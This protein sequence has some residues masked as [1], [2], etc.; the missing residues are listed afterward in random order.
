MSGIV[1]RKVERAPL[2]IIDGLA[3]SGVATVHEA[4]GRTGLMRSFMRPV[5][6]GARIA[7]SAVTVGTL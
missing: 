3:A 7:G 4:Q 5:Y 6:G 2:E 1:V